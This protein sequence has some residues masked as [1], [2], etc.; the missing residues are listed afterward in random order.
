MRDNHDKQTR[1]LLA[2]GNTA[3]Q[4]RFADQQRAMGR[5]ARKIWATDEEAKALRLYLNELR[6]AQDG[7]CGPERA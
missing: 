3:R 7:E 6:A 4:T 2:T 1:N 5:K